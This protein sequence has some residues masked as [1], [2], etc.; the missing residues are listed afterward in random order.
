MSNFNFNKPI[1]SISEIGTLRFWVGL[2]AGI[3]I[4]ITISLLFNYTREILRFIT[5][6]HTDL[7][8]PTRSEFYF[9]NYFF[10][11]LS[12][13]IGLSVSI[14]I[15]LRNLKHHRIKERFYKLL[16]TSNAL[17][18]SLLI[19]MLITRIGTIIALMV[20]GAE[21]YDNELKLYNEYWLIFLLIPLYIF[22]NSWYAVRMVYNSTKWILL[23]FVICLSITVFLSNVTK[24]DQSIVNESYF[25]QFKD[26]YNYIDNEIEKARNEYGV[27]FLP[28][29]IET[30]KKWK[31]DKS[32]QQVEDLKSAFNRNNKLTLDTIILQKMVIHNLKEYYHF[33]YWPYVSPV[34]VFIRLKNSKPDSPEAKELVFT[35]NEMIK[36]VNTP[37]IDYEKNKYITKTEERKGIYVNYMLPAR[38]PYQ[39][40]L[41]RDSILMDKR[42]LE[43]YD[44]LP[45]IKF[46]ERYRN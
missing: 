29:T 31:T 32:S 2:I 46:K 5:G 6:V 34:R 42:F 41:I 44:L 15:W 3:I 28:E 16:S 26:D 19:L 4:T 33:E 25:S 11:S 8:V 45:Q 40:K 17:S 30:L 24:V 35:L 37:K 38:I 21:G 43:Y 36:L 9:F 18:G 1:L 10:T 22:G 39:L 27:Y 12:T 13:V 7:Y 14:T 23:S 20:Y